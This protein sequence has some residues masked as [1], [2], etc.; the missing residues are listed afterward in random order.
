MSIM[1]GDGQFVMRPDFMQI[2]NLIVLL[3]VII[4]LIIYVIRTP[5]I[6]ILLASMGFFGIV[7]LKWPAQIIF[8]E[9]LGNNDA[10]R[11]AL[12]GATEEF[13]RALIGAILLKSY[14]ENREIALITLVNICAILALSFTI[15]EQWTHIASLFLQTNFAV[16]KPAYSYN[17]KDLLL[18]WIDILSHFIVHITL[19]LISISMMLKKRWVG[20][21]LACIGHGVFNYSLITYALWKRA[22]ITYTQIIFVKL[23]L[24]APILVVAL[25]I[26]YK[27]LYDPVP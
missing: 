21:L 14:F 22:N 6:V 25:F 5:K 23:T 4:C 11:H 3:L 20:L 15:I 19:M 1:K 18:V 24:M 16:V 12:G 8:S 7:L 17:D 13:L 27:N 10:L 9:T 2:L 26:Y